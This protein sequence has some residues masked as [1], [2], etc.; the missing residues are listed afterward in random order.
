MNKKLLILPIALIVAFLAYT[1]VLAKP[2]PKGKEKIVGTVY[3]LPKDFLLNL[4]DGRY[5]KLT[6]ALVLAPGQSNGAVAEAAPPAADT[7]GTLPEEAVVRSIVTDA[8]TD[9]SGGT[10]ISTPGRSRI[11][12]DI[13]A[14]LRAHTDLKVNDV[15]FTDVAV[16]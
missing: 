16:Q 11:R 14:R 8:V 1:M 4:N 15:L 12:Q 6:V 7:I 5:A 13:L 9:Q 3:V 10:I 2:A